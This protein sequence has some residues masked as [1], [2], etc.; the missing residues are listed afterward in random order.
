VFAAGVSAGSSY[1]VFLSYAHADA[2]AVKELAAALKAGGVN[3]WLD[4]SEIETF[5]AISERI[6]RGL[7]QSKAFLA[8]YSKTYPKRR[9]CQYELT[10]AFVGA[11]ASQRFERLLTINPEASDSH[12]QPIELRNTKYLS[13]LVSKEALAAGVASIAAHV[14]TIGTPFGEPGALAPPQWH[15]RRGTGSLRFVGRMEQMWAVHSGL[16]DDRAPFAAARDSAGVAQITGLGGVGKSLLAEEYALRFG[17]AYPAGIFWLSALGSDMAGEADVRRLEASRSDQLSVIGAQLNVPAGNSAV[18]LEAGLRD[19]FDKQGQRGLWVVDDV[20]GGLPAEH[21]RAWFAPHPVL[22]TLL[23]TRSSEYGALAASIQLGVLPEEDAYS[24]LTQRVKPRGA[25]EEAAAHAAVQA[26]GAHALALDVAGAALANYEGATPFQDFVRELDIED[27]DSLEMAAELADALPNGHEKSIAKT[28]LG[29]IRS[30]AEP[31][32]DVLRLASQLAAAPIAEV[33]LAVIPV[34]DENGFDR[35]RASMTFRLAARDLQRYALAERQEAELWVMHPLITRA[36]RYA[37]GKDARTGVLR[38]AALMV[39]YRWLSDLRAH[40]L[41]AGIELSHAR[42]LAA[43]GQGAGEFN[44]LQMVANLDEARGSY[45]TAELEWRDLLSRLETLPHDERAALAMQNNLAVALRK[46]GDAKQARDLQIGILKRKRELFG[47][48]DPETIAGLDNLGVTLT[49]LGDFEGAIKT[50]ASALQLY[51]EVE[52]PEH[53][54]T[55]IAMANLGNALRR[56]G[57]LQEAFELNTNLLKLRAKVLGPAH[58]GTLRT[59]EALGV[60]L[61]ELG[62]PADALP[63]LKSAEEAVA[64]VRGAEDPMTLSVRHNLALALIATGQEKEGRALAAEVLEAQERVLG[65]THP[66]TLSTL[67]TCAFTGIG[68][69]APDERWQDKAMEALR[70]LSASLG[71]K[72]PRTTACA[73]LAYRMLER[74]EKKRHAAV[75]VVNGYL[76]W[77]LQAPAGTLEAAQRA[78]RDQFAQTADG[79]FRLVVA[80]I[81]QTPPSPP[82]K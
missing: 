78:I 53:P 50:H 22:K 30:A 57:R 2:A 19:Y 28:V 71:P 32:R 36:M 40:D 15:P 63:L 37:Y 11:Q 16:N 18:E 33:F 34:A 1:D 24:L 14:A 52:G 51:R 67:E 7:A 77:L 73:W 75:E 66:D 58:P 35:Q 64:R 4:E 45:R 46:A 27:Q 68:S 43:G 81:R 41:P 8:Y 59:A 10:A 80:R 39:F 82:V 23:T 21:L 25:A 38:A 55:L 70:E 44:L 5:A 13:G 49:N 76:E 62:K 20:P 54:D 60:T 26:L 56:G 9:G 29:A 48:K 74:D 65:A 69:S 42:K 47:P 72:D 79:V 6:A 61:S 17:A 31:A 3:V 12:I